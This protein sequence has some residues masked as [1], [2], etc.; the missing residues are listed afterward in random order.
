MSTVYLRTVT[1]LIFTVHL[2]SWSTI[3]VAN[4]RFKFLWTKRLHDVQ[5]NRYSVRMKMHEGNDRIN[6]R[7][8]YMYLCNVLGY[9]LCI[10]QHLTQNIFSPYTQFSSQQLKNIQ[11]SSPWNADHQQE[12]IYMASQFWWLWSWKT[13]FFF[14]LICIYIAGS[15]IQLGKSIVWN[16]FSFTH[17]AAASKNR[18]TFGYKIRHNYY[19]F[20]KR[21][22]SI[23]LK[24]KFP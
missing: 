19:I 18:I 8:R 5:T 15:T 2:A 7:C 4:W 11:T 14:T 6:A 21:M 9:R 22:K 3:H 24:N 10:Y 23:F 12:Q 16:I 13:V 1:F 17:G 20:P